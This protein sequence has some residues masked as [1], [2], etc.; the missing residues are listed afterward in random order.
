M[1]TYQS[2]ATLTTPAGTVSFNASSG[3]TPV[4]NPESCSG[5]DMAPIRSSVDDKSQTNGGIVHPMFYGARHVTLSGTLVIRSASTAAGVV[6]ARG[7]LEQGLITKLASIMNADGTYAWDE[8]GTTRTITVRCDQPILFSG[9]F[10]K[11][12]VFGLVAASPTIT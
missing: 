1:A 2:T 3:D 5:L 10:Q 6:T 4:N 12:Y 9:G 7:T 11:T 8:G